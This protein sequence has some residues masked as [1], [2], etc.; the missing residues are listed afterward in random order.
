VRKKKDRGP[1]LNDGGGLGDNVLPRSVFDDVLLR[2][3]MD[4]QKKR[5]SSGFLKI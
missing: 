4:I 1:G 2:L 3:A 5:G